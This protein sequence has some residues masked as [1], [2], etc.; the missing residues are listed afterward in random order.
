MVAVSATK[1]FVILDKKTDETEKRDNCYQKS[2]AKYNSE[3]FS[4]NI[5]VT[6][7]LR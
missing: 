3:P 4:S 6:M 2:E 1:I 5:R 7:I